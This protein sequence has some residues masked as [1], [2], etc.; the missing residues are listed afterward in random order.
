MFAR[1][2][3]LRMEQMEA[4]QLMAVTGAIANTSLTTAI[5]PTPSG[6]VSAYVQNGNL[7]VNEASGYAGTDNGVRIAQLADGHIRVMGVEANNS[8]GAKSLINGWSYQDFTVT[9]GLFVNLGGGNDRV[10]IGYDDGTGAP[11]FNG[12]SIN[13]GA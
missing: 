2:R 6:D 9:G 12:M 7:Y 4:R 5:Y 10:H 8:T 3:K 11:T 13:V 1:G